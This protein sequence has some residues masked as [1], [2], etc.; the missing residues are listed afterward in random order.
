M[1]HLLKKKYKMIKETHIIPQKNSRPIV[2]DVTYTKNNTP[3]PIVIFCHGYKGFKDW[4]CWNL[5]AETLAKKALFF[6]KFNFSHNGGTPEQPIDFPDL[7]AFGENNFS[8]E[9]DD[10]DTVINW[11]M[12]P[13]FFYANEIDTTKIILVGHSRGGGIA[14]IKT[15]EDTRISKLVS[16]AAPSDYKVRFPDKAI[17]ATWKKQGVA[18][19]ENTRTK[20]QMPHFYQ[21][22]EDFLANEQRLTISRA[23]KAIRIP[24]LIVH[25][26]AD[27]TVLCKEAESIHQWSKASELLLIEGANHVFGAMH[28][29]NPKKLPEDLALVA[30]E[31]IKFIA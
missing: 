30:N 27:E 18:Y 6:L 1:F 11:L 19:I 13:D 20:Q 22:Y 4:G 29:W 8:K 10:L 17:L 9:L 5:L 21:F 16:L 25:G 7:T 12:A 14:T 26:T 23:A 2:L 3:K 15:A 31:L 28:P 24:H